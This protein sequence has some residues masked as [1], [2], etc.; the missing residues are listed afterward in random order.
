MKNEAGKVRELYDG[1]AANYLKLVQKSNY[2]GPDW[3]L[4]IVAPG[5]QAPNLKVLDLGCGNGINVANLL[6]LNP[7]ILAT[8]VDISPKMIDAAQ[9][10]GMY[11]TLVCQSLDEGLTFSDDQSFD[12]VIALGCLEFVNDVDFALMEA[13]RV[14]KSAGYFYSTFQHFE[15]G[16][17]RAPRQMRSGEVL[18]FAYS[19]AEV[20]AKLANAG[21][22]VLSHETMIGYTGGAPCP[23]IFTIAQKK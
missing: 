4:K 23:Y 9:Q 15:E 6:T 21:F 18:H 1:A 5:I 13:A 10:A 16:D 22:L 19:M 17:P 7:T 8:G 12:M 3:L 14:C 11:Q 20:L 2:I